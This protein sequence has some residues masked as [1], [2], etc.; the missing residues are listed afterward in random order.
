M[1]S[2]LM[3]GLKE[4]TLPCIIQMFIRTECNV[5]ISVRYSALINVT[6]TKSIVDKNAELQEKVEYFYAVELL[7]KNNQI[8]I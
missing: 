5:E 1:K 8:A 6:T 4:L 7:Y 2:F 3:S